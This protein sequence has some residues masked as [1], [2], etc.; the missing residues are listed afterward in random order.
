MQ[1]ARYC[2]GLFLSPAIEEF[3]DERLAIAQDAVTSIITEYS[4]EPQI[5]GIAFGIAKVLGLENDPYLVDIASETIMDDDI[6]NL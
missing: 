1:V 5:I 3:D 6:R 4:N 2:V